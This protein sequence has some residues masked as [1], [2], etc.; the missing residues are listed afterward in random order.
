MKCFF[1]EKPVNPNGSYV[2]VTSE[3]VIDGRLED[4]RVRTVHTKCARAIDEAAVLP[5]DLRRKLEG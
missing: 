4:V 3:S 1:C 5:E 2:Q